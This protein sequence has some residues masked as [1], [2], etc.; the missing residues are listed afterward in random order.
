MTAT[1][2]TAAGASDSLAIS[3]GNDGTL[4]I[5]SGPTG[6]KVNAVSVDSAGKVSFPQN[7]SG[8]APFFSVRA[9]AYFNGTTAGTNAPTAGGNVTTITRNSTGN[10]TANF[11][12]AMPSPLMAIAGS[13][14][15]ATVICTVSFS[16][17]SVTFSVNTAS[18][19]AQ[20]DATN[21]TVMFLC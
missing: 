3:S 9:W 10:Y 7:Q 20:I 19:G 8:S 11:T 17:T 1:T 21:I 12:T 16:T 2:I 14:S 18:T 5:Q 13:A 6:A 15:V 4:V